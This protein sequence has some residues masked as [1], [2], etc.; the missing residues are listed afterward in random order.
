[1][2]KLMMKKW[3]ESVLYAIHFDCYV[4]F[5]IFGCIALYVACIFGIMRIISDVIA[6][7]FVNMTILMQPAIF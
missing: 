3:W 4:Y 6:N 5:L 1:M 2:L 7:H